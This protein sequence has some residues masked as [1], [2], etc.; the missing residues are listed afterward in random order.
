MSEHEEVRVPAGR[1]MVMRDDLETVIKM[2][3]SY[4]ALIR[5]LPGEDNDWPAIDRRHN[6]AI[7]ALK[8]RLNHSAWLENET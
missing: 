6:Q 1:V 7:A 4:K 5:T 3:E 8:S 2:A